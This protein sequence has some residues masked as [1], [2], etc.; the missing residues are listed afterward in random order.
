M[1][2]PAVAA[3]PPASDGGSWADRL[4]QIDRVELGLTMTLAMIAISMHEMT[5]YTQLGVMT[6]AVSALV[7][8]PLQWNPLLWFGLVV[9]FLVSFRATWFQQNNHDYLKTYW[10]AAV[11]LSLLAASPRQAL[12]WN[13]RIVIGL[14]FLF[15]TLWKVLSPDF[16][17]GEFFHYF[18]LQDT[19]F[20]LIARFLGG[21]S[22]AELA[23]GRTERVLYSAFGDPAAG[24]AVAHAARVGWIS[25]LLTWWTVLMEGLVAAAFLSPLGTFLSKWRD[26]VMVV[27]MVS[28][29]IIAP[30]LFFAWILCGMGVVQAEPA[31]GRLGLVL[32][33]GVFVLILIRFYVPV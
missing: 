1:M 8:R 27:F 13:A 30:I 7:I 20:E 18:L 15:A 2:D 24:T 28:T 16:L 5:W 9:V 3:P 17:N 23:P 25:P 21:V 32:Y 6:L 33:I 10:C 11:G 22:P 12:A 29:Y 14:C 4:R 26:V 19:R 31:R